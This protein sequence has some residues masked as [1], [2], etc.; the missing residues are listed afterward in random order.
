MTTTAD[1]RRC[2]FPPC[3]AA[4]TSTHANAV[5]CSAYCRLRGSKMRRFGEITVLCPRCGQ[6]DHV[7]TMDDGDRCLGCAYTSGSD[8]SLDGIRV[9]TRKGANRE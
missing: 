5:Y 4:L 7:W 3:R 1:T 8:L 6:F 2:D 9:L